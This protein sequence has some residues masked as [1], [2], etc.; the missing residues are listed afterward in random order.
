MRRTFILHARGAKL[1]T[2]L[3][4]L[5]TIR[6]DPDTTPAIVRQINQTLRKTIE[7]EGR[8]SRLEGDWWQLSIT[9]RTEL[10]TS[11]VSLLSIT[12]DRV[13]ALEVAGRSWD[14]DGGLTTRYRSEATKERVG[15][16][17]IFY[18]WKGERPRDPNAPE[19]EGTGEITLESVD[20]AN[21]YYIVTRSNVRRAL[22]R[23]DLRHL[24]A[25]RPRRQGRA[26]RQ[27]RRRACRPHR[28]AHRGVEGAGELVSPTRLP[29]LPAARLAEVG[30]ATIEYI[31]SGT[32]PPTIVLVNGAGG[33]LDG[34]SRVFGPLLRYGMVVA[35][36]RPGI[37][38]SSRPTEP[39]TGA[40]IVGTLRDLLTA[41]EAPPPY[42]LLG[43]SLG[44][45]YVQLFARRLPED[46]C[47]VVMVEAAHPDDRAMADLQPGWVRALNS[48]LRIG[49]PLR[50]DRAFDET[51]WVDR[52]CRQIEQAPPFPDVPLAVV[53]AA[54]PPPSRADARRGGRPAIGE[55]GGP[56]GARPRKS[57]LPRGR[58]EPLPAAQ[59]AHG[60][61]GR[62][63]LGHRTTRRTSRA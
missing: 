36:N 41:I 45:L 54:R 7:A 39:Q 46:V 8:I 2:D 42:I 26:G 60:H 33:P 35:Y 40:L 10:D 24:P 25:R 59:R 14:A 53:T 9:T 5:T 13:G 27:G 47:G 22:P 30:G 1:P 58:F 19:F 37:G 61:R 17:G 49:N 11:A 48:V 43:H 29:T 15:P 52:T 50:R 55:P 21:G 63:P 31:A 16:A 38:R 20:R 18:F 6:Y 32:S 51:R 56:G 28:A 12:R 23:E 4:G 3:L 57:A 62:R 44:G 34:W